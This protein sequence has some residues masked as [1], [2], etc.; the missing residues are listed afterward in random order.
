M[1]WPGAKTT[2]AIMTQQ[3]STINFLYIPLLESAIAQKQAAR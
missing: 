2:S 3:Q 1:Q